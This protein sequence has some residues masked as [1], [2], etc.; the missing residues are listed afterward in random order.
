VKLTI[1]L[2]LA[3]RLKKRGAIHPLPHYLFIA[4]C[5]VKHR[6][7]FYLQLLPLSSRL[8][9]TVFPNTF[10]TVVYP[11]SKLI[12]CPLSRDL[13]DSADTTLYVITNYVVDNDN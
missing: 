10:F 5:L 1:H 7:N 12:Y 4:W 11:M 3:Q 8:W 13:I 6:D 9:Y 2:H